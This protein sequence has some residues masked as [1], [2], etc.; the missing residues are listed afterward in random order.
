ML[1]FRISSRNETTEQ[2][3]ASSCVCVCVGGGGGGGFFLF[4][5]NYILLV[6]KMLLCRNVS[7]L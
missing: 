1:L 7:S 3:L 2:L 6:G 4:K 5:N